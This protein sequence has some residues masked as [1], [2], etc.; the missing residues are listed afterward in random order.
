MRQHAEFAR[1]LIILALIFCTSLCVARAQDTTGTI[2]G[3][4]KDVSGSAVKGATVTVT[5]EEKKIVVRTVTTGNEGEYSIPS[6][7]VGIYTVTVEAPS[8]KKS[9]QTHVKLDVN[10]RRTID[11]SLE[12]G[13]ISEVVTVEA[14]PLTV[15]LTTPTASTVITGDQVRELSINNRNFVQLVTLAPGV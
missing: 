14:D 10:S 6:V 9:A 2:N 5:D 12:A 4:V 1:R 7:P 3:T 8:F 11:V 15:E 13:N